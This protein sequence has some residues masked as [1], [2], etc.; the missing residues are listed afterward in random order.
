M[1]MQKN[2]I[3]HFR[4]M[5]SNV[6]CY[7]NIILFTTIFSIDKCIEKVVN[8][9]LNKLTEKDTHSRINSIISWDFIIYSFYFI[10]F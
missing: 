7:K 9:L 6:C 8:R 3:S 10:V 1:N 4:P 5:C 2:S